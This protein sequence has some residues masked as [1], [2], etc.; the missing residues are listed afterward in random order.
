M[1][2]IDWSL[3]LMGLPKRRF[4]AAELARAIPEPPSTSLLIA[5]LLNVVLVLGGVGWMF[6]AVLQPAMVT[7]VLLHILVLLLAL[8]AVW[9]D[10][11]CRAGRWVYY[12]L[13]LP[14]AFAGGVSAGLSSGFGQSLSM[15]SLSQPR[16]A[17]GLA[18]GLLLGLGALGLWFAI[19]HRHQ[20]VVMRLA[21]LDERDRAIEMARQLGS[22][23]IQPHFLFN[24]L[25]SLQHWVASGDP[26]AAPLLE[27]L[28]GYLRATL[29]LFE[30]RWLALGQELDAVRRYLEVMQAR[31][32]ERLAFRI[33]ADPSLLSCQLPPG[34]L[35]TLVENAVEHGLSPLLRGGMLQL[36]VMRQGDA[37][38]VH[39]DDNGPGLAEPGLPAPISASSAHGPLG[40]INTRARLQQAFA[41]A[42]RLSL[43]NR[44]EGGCR[45]AL[46]IPFSFPLSPEVQP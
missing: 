4:T 22:A 9:R 15:A 14:T 36:Q 20:Y 18:C 19:V 39:V 16:F 29:P 8:W 2:R 42:A 26:R 45:A 46:T 3:I 11:S 6:H 37:V 10:P 24:T 17:L 12:G 44:P 35:L 7:V 5:V 23:Q 32:G 1:R 41:G 27:S 38:Q 30:H 25:A 21:E 43:S 13:P 31:L 40:L 28:T 33:E 34:V